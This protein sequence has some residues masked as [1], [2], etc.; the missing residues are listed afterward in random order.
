MALAYIDPSIRLCNIEAVEVFGI[1]NSRGSWAPYGSPNMAPSMG[2][3][4]CGILECVVLAPCA[5]RNLKSARW[6]R[7][8]SKLEDSEL[9]GMDCRLSKGSSE[10]Y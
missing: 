7:S 9:Q 3:M 4:G 5:T 1:R 2:P 8:V 10:L 6:T